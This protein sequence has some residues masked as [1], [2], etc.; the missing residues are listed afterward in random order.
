[1][2]RPSG[3]GETFVMAEVVVMGAELGQV[4]KGGRP[5]V[6]DFDDP[7]VDLQSGD[8]IAAGDHTGGI[9]LVEGPPEG[10]G[11]GPA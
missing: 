8:R 11:D 4:P 10:G 6:S 2:A 3:Q 7:V 9:P 5:V 1:V